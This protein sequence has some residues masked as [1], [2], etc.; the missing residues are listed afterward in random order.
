[1]INNIVR[2]GIRISS[3]LRFG[4]LGPFGSRP[5]KEKIL[6]IIEVAVNRFN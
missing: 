5:I 2:M 3:D 4:S 6:A 1:M